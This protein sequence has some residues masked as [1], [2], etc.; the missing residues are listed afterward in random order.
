M[1]FLGVSTFNLRKLPAFK[2]FPVKLSDASKFVN[3]PSE[4]TSPPP[5][6]EKPQ[7]TL[8]KF[9]YYF[10]VNYLVELRPIWLPSVS[11]QI[12]TNP[13]SPIENFGRNTFPPRD[14]IFASCETQ[15]SELK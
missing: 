2:N 13:N 15:S 3:T 9:K 8:R 12:E 7:T 1:V 4:I 11:S 5:Y 6:T 10:G 14:V